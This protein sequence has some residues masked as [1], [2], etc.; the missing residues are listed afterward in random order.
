M[1]LSQAWNR[2]EELVRDGVIFGAL[3]AIQGKVTMTDFF[4]ERLVK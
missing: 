2:A 4:R 3:V 1:A